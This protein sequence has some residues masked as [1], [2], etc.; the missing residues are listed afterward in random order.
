[1]NDG[2]PLDSGTTMD[3]EASGMPVYLELS[4]VA[5]ALGVSPATVRR[6]SDEGDLNPVARTK[7]G[8][9]LFTAADVEAERKRRQK[10]RERKPIG[11]ER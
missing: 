6:W 2:I 8:C 4:D 9:R 5:L 11:G 7:R 10:E 3:M 1:M